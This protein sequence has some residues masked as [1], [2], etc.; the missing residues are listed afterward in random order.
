[1]SA[2]K[3]VRVGGDSDYKGDVDREARWQAGLPL[4]FPFLARDLFQEDV[5]DGAHHNSECVIK[6]L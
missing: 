6:V 4:L 2:K 5:N 3:G 1:M